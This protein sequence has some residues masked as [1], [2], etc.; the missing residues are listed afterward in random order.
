MKELR[1]QDIDVEST[2][3]FNDHD[4]NRVKILFCQHDRIIIKKKF[5]LIIGVFF[6]LLF[7][8]SILVTYYGSTRNYENKKTTKSPIRPTK[9]PVNFRLPRNF[10]PFEYELEV[11][12]YVGVNE[13]LWSADKNYHF[14]GSIIMH[15]TCIKTSNEIVFHSKNLILSSIEISSENDQNVQIIK[16]TEADIETD[17]VY[18]KLNKM[19]N[20]NNT[21]QLIVNFSGVLVKELYGYYRSSYV[22]SK[23]QTH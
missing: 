9:A 23:N 3:A 5:V 22:D 4:V 20:L 18:V 15:L 14:E 13:S 2:L 16:S 8:G 6:L 17:F 19:C 21:Y 12:T 1:L 7:I 11:K 10:L